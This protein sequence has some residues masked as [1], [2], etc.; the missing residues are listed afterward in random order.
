MERHF[1]RAPFK[2][3]AYVL[4]RSES[5]K[6]TTTKDGRFIVAA[7]PLTLREYYVAFI[8]EVPFQAYVADKVELVLPDDLERVA[9]TAKEVSR[10]RGRIS[11]RW[12]REEDFEAEEEVEISGGLSRTASW[13]GLAEASVTG[14]GAVRTP[15]ICKDPDDCMRPATALTLL[16]KLAHEYKM[17]KYRGAST[18]DAL[19]KLLS[20]PKKKFSFFAI[21]DADVDQAERLLKEA[22]F[23]IERRC[24]ESKAELRIEKI[25]ESKLFI[26]C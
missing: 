19:A 2:Y 12:T 22:G 8:S 10:G 6:F 11:L 5:K 20:D 18:V 15:H 4:L 24:R 21:G 1:F 23:E 14:R 25:S 9:S 16:Y 26:Y 3:E 17:V 13:M 7:E